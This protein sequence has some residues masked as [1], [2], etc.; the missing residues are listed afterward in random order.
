MGNAKSIGARICA[1]V[2]AVTVCVLMTFVMTACGD[3]NSQG[4]PGPAGEKGADGLTPFIGTNGNWWIG[5]VDTGIA[6]TGRNGRDGVDGAAGADGNDGLN[7][8]DGR[9][10]ADAITPEFSYD[11]DSGD[12]LVSYDNGYSWSS[13]VNVG[14]MV[15]DGK[16]GTSISSCSI[17]TLGELV[18]EYSDGTS[19]NLGKIVAKDGVGINDVLMTGDGT[20]VIM[21]SN[22]TQIQFEGLK[23]ADGVDGNDGCTPQ[24]RIDGVSREWE[25]SYDGGDT[26]QSLGSKSTGEPG[27]DGRTPEI[28]INDDGYW[29]ICYDGTRWV[30]TSVK[31]TGINGSNGKDG[32]DGRGITSVQ[33]ID[34]YLYI[35]YTDGKVDKLGPVSN[36]ASIGGEVMGGTVADVYTDSLAFYPIGDGSEYGVSIG[37]A[38]YMEN[39]IIPSTYNGK[40]VTTILPGAFNAGEDGNACLKSITIPSSIVKIGDNA[41]ERCH[42]LEEIYIPSSVSEIGEMAFSQ[43]TEIHFE[44]AEADVPLNATWDVTVIGGKEIKWGQ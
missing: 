8:T 29:E 40:P 42:A 3:K 21:L 26:W 36:G 25:I 20:L 5:E 23:G 19:D 28:R 35:T 16:D 37:N 32:N 10:G 11:A 18:V 24:L 17:N 38:L 31:A 13:L 9:D 27:A 41:F 7:G 33:L 12:I 34:N 4:V 22:G 39:I 43:N 2:L 1:M 44:I 6:A 30:T 14:A 15:A